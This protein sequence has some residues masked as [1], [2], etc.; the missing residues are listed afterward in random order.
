VK[1]CTLVAIEEVQL[2][3]DLTTR[4]FRIKAEVFSFRN[5]INNIL[6]NAKKYSL[7]NYKIKAL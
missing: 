1:N 5:T 6:D 3:Y 2:I 4:N 7:A